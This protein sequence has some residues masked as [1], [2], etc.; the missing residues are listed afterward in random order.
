ME[1]N[2]REPRIGAVLI[3]VYPRGGEPC[4]VFT[5]RSQTVADHRGQIS[6]PGGAREHG[7]ATLADTAL[8]ETEEELGI[9][10]TDVRVLGRLDDVYVN[11]SNFLIAPHIG[12]IE[13]E[14]RFRAAAEEVDEVIEIPLDR[15]RDPSSLKHQELLIRDEARRTLFYEFGGHQIWGAT[16]RVIELFLRSAF[17]DELLPE[18]LRS[19]P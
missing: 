10:A 19:A 4:V 8:R 7:D 11:V 1:L 2:P 17:L 15:L 18:Y 16:Q 13:Y 12:M 9:P 5:K 6:L 14:P 3:L